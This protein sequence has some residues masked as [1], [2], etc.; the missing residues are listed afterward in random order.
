MAFGNNVQRTR[1]S[2][3]TYRKELIEVASRTGKVLDHLTFDLSSYFRV[4]YVVMFGLHGVPFSLREFLLGTYYATRVRGYTYCG[5]LA[6]ICPHIRKTTIK[7][8][9]DGAYCVSI[10]K[11]RPNGMGR[12]V[13]AFTLTGYWEAR[14]NI[15]MKEARATIRDTNS[16]RRKKEQ[17]AKDADNT[18]TDSIDFGSIFEELE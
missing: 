10:G 6:A 16:K 17:S 15:A 13:E 18:D 12:P 7:T 5:E 2:A 4:Q 9:L 1:R 11:Q 14:I 3:D 8:L